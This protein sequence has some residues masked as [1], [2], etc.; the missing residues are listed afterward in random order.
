MFSLVQTVAVL[1]L[2]SRFAFAINFPFESIQL[3]EADVAGNPDIAFGKLPASGNGKKCKTFPGDDNWPSA[4]RW[5]A[6]NSSLGGALVRGIPPAAACYQGPYYDE[7]RCAVVRARQ[8]SSRFASDD[9]TIPFGQWQLDN[10]CPV[11]ADSAAPVYTCNFTSLPQ[12]VVNATTAKHI[13]LA[14]N[15]ARNNN[16]RLTIKN[17]G[18]DFLGRNTGGGAL[19]VWVHPL[20]YFETIPSVQDGHYSGRA[21]KIGAGIMTYELFNEMAKSNFTVGV[22]GGATVSA[23]GGWM[24][25]GGFSILTSRFGLM[26]DQVLSVEIVTADGKFVH[27]APDENEDLFWAIRGGGPSNYGIVTSA[28]IKIRDP[29]SISSTT[30]NW[31]TSPGTSAS[32]QVSNE[33]FWKG[34]NAYFSHLVRITDAKGIGWNYIRTVPPTATTPRTFTFI[35]Q[36]TLNNF[37]AADAKAF[38]APLIADLNKVGF[39]LSNPEP[40]WFPTY[41]QQGFRP[42]PDEGVSNGR[43]GSR[44]FPRKNFIDP[45]SKEFLAAMTAIRSFVEDGGYMWHSVDYTPTLETA[46]YPGRTNAVNPHLRNAIM[47]STGFDFASYGPETTAAEKIASHARLNEYLNKL[48]AATPGSGAYM[49]EAD[50]DEPNFQESFYGSNYEKLARFKKKTDPWHV[51]HAV[52]AVGSDEWEV[53]GTQG[54]T[55]QQ[56]RLCRV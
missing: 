10:P 3:T 22:A 29:I 52:T 8:G 24:Q 13:Q 46:G 53:E 40:S 37:S 19:Q 44:L 31:Q 11:P 51:F 35:G 39:N 23:I 36:I 32:P 20:K 41:A 38:A 26:A 15:F 25:G 21:A 16:I 5:S 17:T 14:V 6:F 30:L 9:P 55:T 7:A 54:L 48:R 42:N 4:E 34:V 18:H 43:F 45:T 1:S 28:V 49:N 2:A 33:T 12:Y 27:A 56:G 50:P 47:H